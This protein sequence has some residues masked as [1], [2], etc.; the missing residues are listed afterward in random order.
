MNRGDLYWM[1]LPEQKSRPAVVLSPDFLIQVRDRV[2]TAPCTSRRMEEVTRTE[3]KLDIV[4]LDK[5]TK[6]QTQDMGTFRKSVFGEYIRPLSPDEMDT[7]NK[8]IAITTG[9][10]SAN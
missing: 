1:E 9:L 5:P 4:K 7:L 10:W 2:L 6:V 3:V 8:A